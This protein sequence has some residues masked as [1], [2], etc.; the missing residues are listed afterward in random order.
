M[1]LTITFFQ[2]GSLIA[3]LAN[4]IAVPW[5]TVVVVPLALLSAAAFAVAPA[6]LPWCLKLALPAASASWS[7]IESLGAVPGASWSFPEP[8]LATLLLALLGAAA[9][10]LP[11][12]VP[13]RAL[14][15]LLVVPLVLP[16]GEPPPDGAFELD[17]IDVGQGLSVLVRTSGHALLYDAGPAPPNGIDMGEAAVV[18]ALTALGVARLDRVVVSHGDN[19]HAG[20]VRAVV[21]RFPP[22][23]VER[24]DAPGG[25]S[26]RAGTSW[27]WD[28]VRFEY[29]H[30]P[31]D[32]PYLGN[33]SC[34]VLKVSAAGHSALLP[35]DIPESIESRL[36]GSG[37]IVADV[38]VAPHH[39]SK[40]SSSAPFIAAV[41]PATVLF[42]AGY[43]SRFG[44]PHPDAIARYRDRGA[45]MRNTAST[46]LLR[47]RSS[48]LGVE[49]PDAYRA[50]HPRYWREP[51]AV[52]E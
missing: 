10:L 44:H 14:G 49:G 3:P 25:P 12:G 33:E 46:G 52:T 1:P 19:D 20:G 51:Y 47:V 24:S 2:Q 26:C 36:V 42:S 45:G 28:G 41:G 9:L 8:G 32:F 21:R 16:R 5:I 27:E 50:L 6:L 22:E 17:V 31:R 29:L 37:D 35:G 34:C 7:L 13:G 39:G 11:R 23:A 48:A 38:L 4:A 43:R 30:P 15:A 40:G 18:P